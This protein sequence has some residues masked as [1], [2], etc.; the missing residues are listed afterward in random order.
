MGTVAE[1]A[2]VVADTRSYE[3]WLAR[4]GP[5]YAPDLDFKH[6][7]MGDP[8]TPFPF[9]RGTYY[10][11]ARHWQNQ[12]P[13][14]LNAPRVLA[15][16]D[17]HVEN[18][19]TWRDSDGRLCWGLNDFDE[20]DELPYTNDLVRL[21]AGAR[22]ARKG[23]HLCVKLGAACRAIQ[24]G[25]RDCLRAG[26]RP[27]VLEER[28][29]HLRAMAMAADRYPPRFWERMTRLLNDPVAQLPA[30][31]KKILTDDFPAEGLDPAFRVR[32]R[33]GMGSLGKQR[34]VALAEWSGGWICRE[35]KAVVPPATVWLAGTKRM[36]SS[37][38]AEAVGGA[39]RSADPFYRPGPAWVVRRLA[40]H[41]SRIELAHLAGTDLERILY[42]MGAET[43]NIHLGS[44]GT[45]TA[46]LK[47]LAAR[48]EDWLKHAARGMT[49]EILKDWKL[50]RRATPARLS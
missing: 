50:W 39:V 2:D 40:P 9:F 34:F 5:V 33:V 6:A 32:P 42:A 26:G 14:L 1:T 18:F 29:T 20:A 4:F 22:L 37:R 30:A 21:A 44:M 23:S 7:R 28:H 36:G 10:R 3:S 43:A 25:Y 27:F 15:V 8:R 13:A 49:K 41:C 19:G 38:M 48:P 46:I 31:L 16:G 11:W 45:A 35:A 24:N 47:D 12:G 17:L